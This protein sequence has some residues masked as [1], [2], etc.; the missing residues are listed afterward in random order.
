MHQRSCDLRR[1]DGFKG[2]E[3]LI[4]YGGLS[5]PVF[6]HA[7]DFFVAACQVPRQLSRRPRDVHREEHVGN[8]QLRALGLVYGGVVRGAGDLYVHRNALSEELVR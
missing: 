5:N 3:S 1:C 8:M 4:P 2:G 6:A 7:A